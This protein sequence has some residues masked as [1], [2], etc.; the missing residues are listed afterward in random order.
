MGFI[1]LSFPLVLRNPPAVKSPTWSDLPSGEK[2]VSKYKD[3]RNQEAPV[4][5]FLTV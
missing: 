5:V 1:I 2:V 3:K 4:G